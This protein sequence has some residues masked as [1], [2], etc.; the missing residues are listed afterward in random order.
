MLRRRGGAVSRGDVTAAV[1]LGIQKLD[2]RT[3]DE[4]LSETT[5]AMS[6]DGEYLAFEEVVNIDG[7]PE[8]WLNDVETAMFRA[9]K[10][11]LIRALE[12]AKSTSSLFRDPSPNVW[13]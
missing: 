4:G 10:G 9:T 8:D 3:N 6:P 7:R 5:G 11:H 13:R 2:I 12:T 1:L